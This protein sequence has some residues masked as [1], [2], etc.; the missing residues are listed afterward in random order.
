M[1]ALILAA[2]DG[3]R[4]E[5]AVPKVLLSLHGV[6][7]ILRT[8]LTLREAGIT[9]MI[10]VIGFKGDLVREFLGDG[11]RYGVKIRYTVNSGYERENATSILKAEQLVDEKFLLVMGDHL[12]SS[13]IIK[14]LMRVNGDLVVGADLDPRYVDMGEATKLLLGAGEVKGI[15]KDLKEFNAVDAGIFICS[16]KIFPV[17]KECV[18]DGRDEWSDSIREYAKHHKVVSY[19]VSSLFW[20]DVDTKEDVRKAETLL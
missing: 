6:P 10:V 7:L 14:G 3:T 15:G 9:E 16:K 13:E 4:M 17:V 11:S 2:G 8:V 5:S 19:D 1:K 20:F 12:F 18:E